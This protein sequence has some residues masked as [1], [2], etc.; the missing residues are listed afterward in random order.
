METGIVL[1]GS[2]VKS[3]REGKV[4]FT[5]SYAML[6]KGEV[7]LYGL[8]IAP[9]GKASIFN[10]VAK[11]T[12]KLLVHKA[13]IRKLRA[14]T[15]EKGLSLVPLSTYFN[16]RGLIKIEL[17]TCRGKKLFDKREDIAKK[18]AARTI[19]QLMKAR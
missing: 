19:K 6:Q 12:R 18:E 13:E 15:E 2:E 5:D 11:R 16:E 14:M 1:T 8:D 7:Y 9:Y 3:M 4:N 17:G 10:H